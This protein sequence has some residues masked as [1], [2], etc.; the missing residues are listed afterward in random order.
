MNAP[1]APA[2][3]PERKLPAFVE[4]V[5][6]DEEVAEP[7]GLAVVERPPVPFGAVPLPPNPEVP[8][9]VLEG[10]LVPVAPI[11]LPAPS[12]GDKPPPGV[13][14]ADVPVA[15]DRIDDATLDF[16]LATALDAELATL[17]ATLDAM[18][19]ATLEATLELAVADDA[20][21]ELELELLEDTSEQERSKYGVVLRGLPFVIPKLGLVWAASLSSIVYHQVLVLPKRGHPT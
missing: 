4:A 9:T 2:T 10:A 1:M 8:V 7:V 15:A 18:L 5:S 14:R 11:P 3:E 21:L 17:D 12:D 20:T 16:E 19:D 13:A 6:G